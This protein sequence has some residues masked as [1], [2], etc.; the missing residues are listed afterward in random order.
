MLG[1]LNPVSILKNFYGCLWVV[2]RWR[3]TMLL[4]DFYM[5]FLWVSLPGA[6][7]RH[8]AC[9]QSHTVVRRRA[10]VSRNTLSLREA[11]RI[12]GPFLNPPTGKHW[13][14]TVAYPMS[15]VPKSDGTF[16]PVSNLSFRSPLDSVNGFIPNSESTTEYPPFHKVAK[17]LVAIG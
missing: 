4:M 8:N 17:S 11:G 1:G 7:G 6:R 5:V 9:G 16:R 14:N 13:P 3:E 2:I 12:F 10:H 15:E